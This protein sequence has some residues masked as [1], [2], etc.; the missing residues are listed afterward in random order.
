MTQNWQQILFATGVVSMTLLGGCAVNRSV[1]SQIEL[2][3][4]SDQTDNQKRASIRLQLAIGYYERRQ[5]GVALD[6]IKQALAADPDYS[7]A[8][9]VRALIYMNM[10]ETELA[11][12]NFLRA[13]RLTPNNPDLHNNYGWFL[14]Q[15]GRPQQSIA[16]FETASN[17]RSYQSPAKALNNAGVCS[18]KL[19]DPAAAEHYFSQAFRYD[20]ANPSANTN[21]AK[22]YF[23]RRDYERARF[24]ISRVLKAGVTSPD[25]LWLGIK[26]ERKIGDRSAEKSFVTQLARRH[27]KSA[28]YA[29]Y[30]RGAFDE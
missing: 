28:E 8:Y 6:E 29:S 15:N 5:T 22:L 9:N 4:S 2:P 27:P 3:T 21:L 23:D 10:G 17:D 11:E 30:Q 20:P 1:D 18:L 26:I 25:V 12:E 7:D 19:K 14:C 13:L 16:H 24:Y